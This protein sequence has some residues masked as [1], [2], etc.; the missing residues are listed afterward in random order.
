M[1]A[2]HNSIPCGTGL[3]YGLAIRVCVLPVRIKGA[4][5][6]L[7]TFENITEKHFNTRVRYAKAQGAEKAEKKGLDRGFIGLRVQ[8]RAWL[9]S[10]AE[11]APENIAVCFVLGLGHIAF[12][13]GAQAVYYNENNGAQAQEYA[14][15]YAHMKN[16]P[17]VE[18][19]NM[20]TAEKQAGG[21]TLAQMLEKA[22][23]TESENTGF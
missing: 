11:Y 8:G 2:R 21:L 16:L 13:A 6:A 18:H 9:E 7:L 10:V 14:K 23:A 3:R 12:I 4:V 20:P 22:G 17:L 5:M 15:A 1:F 19:S